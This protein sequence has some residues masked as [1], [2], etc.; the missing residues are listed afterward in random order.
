[1][2]RLSSDL[3]TLSHEAYVYLYPLVLMD[4]TRMQQLSFEAGVRPGFGPANRFHHLRAFPS[5]DFRTVVRPNFDTLYSSA[6]LDLTAGPLVLH[7]PDTRDRYYM[8][9][10]LD[11]WTDVFANPGKRTT[12]TDAR[13]FVVVGPGYTGETPRDTHVIAAPTAYVWIIGRTQ[14]NGPADYPAVHAVQDDYR[15]TALH[16][17]PDHRAVPDIDVDTDTEPLMLTNR[18]SAVALFAR[19]ARVMKV[20]PPHATDFS[21]LA[22]IAELGIVPGQ[23]F[24]P[25]AFDV[26][27][28]AEIEA[29]ASTARASI[30]AGIP[31]L[32]TQVNG[33]VS[34]T[35]TMGVYGNNYF[36]RAVVAAVG[37]GANPAEDAVYPVLITDADGDALDGATDYVLHFDADRLPPV[38]A[39][40]SVTM[41][42]AEGFQVA[43]ELNRFALGDRD[44]LDFNAD[45]SL[46][47]HLRHTNP[48][49]DREANWL[50]TPLGPLGVTMRL[51]APGRQVL[52]GRWNPPAVRKA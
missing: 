19:A 33:W 30:L 29:G 50:P 24:D 9:P 7:A 15:I 37:L 10:M 48:G 21:Q 13:D 35:D 2:S 18:M 42:D 26:A 44:P 16:A 32:A 45:G 12:G 3:R 27:Q 38:H 36:P 17:V 41:Y 34:L 14:T 11:M 20:N 1:M 31:D 46:T 8:L 51:Y 28:I 47:L 4:L 23:D 40:W 22:R 6:W 25:G 39:F 5:A 52:N 43:N 49:P